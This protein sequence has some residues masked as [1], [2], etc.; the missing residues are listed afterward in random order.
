MR[1]VIQ[2]NYE[3]MSLWAANFI[4]A[5]ISTHKEDRPFVLGLPTGSSPIGV[6]KELIRKNKAG[7]LSFANVITFNMDEYL[8]LPRE[9][10]QSY[11]YFMHDNFFDHLTDMKPENIHIL[12]GMTKD[13]EGECARYE[14]MILEA[15]GIDLFMGGIGVD[16]HLAFNEP[17]T[18]LSSRTGVRDLTT[19]T[20]IVNSR[21]FGGDPE[22]VPS[23]ALSVGIGTVTDARE[24]L[25]LISGHN[26]A[27]AL[28]RTVEGGVS[29][30]W[31]CSALQLHNAAII[32][33]DEEAC[34]EL[35]VDTYKYFLDI[36]RSQRL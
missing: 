19:D 9:H 16:G 8:G 14:E 36:E 11:W 17:Y 12:D 30:K 32:A 5:K 1:V 29:Q 27:R 26:K 21:F 22:K 10:D 20:R 4:A 28:A 7:E 24:V 2:D 6:Y 18:S 15:G 33:C 13:P 34:G 35:T 31:T 3:K 23:Q 25:V